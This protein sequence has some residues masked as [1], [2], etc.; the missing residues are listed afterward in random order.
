[1]DFESILL[2]EATDECESRRT[3]EECEVN[4]G[5]TGYDDYTCRWIDYLNDP[6]KCRLHYGRE[7]VG[8]GCMEGTC[9]FYGCGGWDGFRSSDKSSMTQKKSYFNQISINNIEN[10]LNQLS[11][12]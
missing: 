12:E 10:N 1:M 8:I 6:T 11:E 7:D 2:D 3:Q 5:E 4:R 9:C